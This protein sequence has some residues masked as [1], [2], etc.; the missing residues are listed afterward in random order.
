MYFITFISSR[1]SWLPRM[2]WKWRSWEFPVSHIFCTIPTSSQTESTSSESS[3]LGLILRL[4]KYLQLQQ[5]NLT[6]YRRAWEEKLSWYDSWADTSCGAKQER[7]W[8]CGDW[9]RW[10]TRPVP[11]VT[12]PLPGSCSAW[13]HA[14]CR[15][16]GPGFN[17]KLITAEGSG[18][19]G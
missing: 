9:W 13:L 3:D 14:W 5:Y 4:W 2:V 8:W 18:S 19:G 16:L 12:P 1:Q 11:T 17:G 10:V 6:V 7:V 15:L